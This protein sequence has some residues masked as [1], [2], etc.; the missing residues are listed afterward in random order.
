VRSTEDRILTSI[1]ASGDEY[2]TT[3][4]EGGDLILHRFTDDVALKAA[5]PPPG[6]AWD[7]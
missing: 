3:P 7:Y 6:W 4:H 2:V 5:E 1:N